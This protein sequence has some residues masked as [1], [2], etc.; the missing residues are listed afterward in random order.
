MNVPV[1]V[2]TSQ[3]KE[4]CSMNKQCLTK[5]TRT[6]PGAAEPTPG[7]QRRG[8][9]EA[10]H[11]ETEGARRR[12]ESAAP[13]APVTHMG[14]QKSH[15]AAEHHQWKQG[16]DGCLPLLWPIR[17]A[18]RLGLSHVPLKHTGM[19]VQCWPHQGNSAGASPKT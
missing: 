16:M 13:P 4:K 9:D 1:R 8:E 19:L 2:Q 17:P 10:T 12:V 7:S 11:R 15:V 18:S 6:N 5:D 14:E 3:Q